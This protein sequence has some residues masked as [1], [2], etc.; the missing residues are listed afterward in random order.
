MEQQTLIQFRCSQLVTDISVAV[1]QQDPCSQAVPALSVDACQGNINVDTGDRKTPKEF[2]ASERFASAMPSAPETSSPSS[3][4]QDERFMT[5]QS[6]FGTVMTE[7]TN[8]GLDAT[9]SHHLSI[10]KK[11]N[12]RFGTNRSQE[13]RDEI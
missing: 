12:D 5:D 9:T 11:K 13:E 3:S 2:T 8:A 6:S 10:Q 1:A 7:D 4:T